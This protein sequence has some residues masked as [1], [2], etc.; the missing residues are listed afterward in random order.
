M[1]LQIK[2]SV[3]GDYLV[4]GSVPKYNSAV[5]IDSSLST[6]SQNAVQNKAVTAAINAKIATMASLEYVQSLY[7]IGTVYIGDTL[8][9]DFGTWE[10]IEGKFL[11]GCKSDFSDLGET[12]GSATVTLTQNNLPH[13]DATINAPYTVS[14]YTYSHNHTFK[15]NSRNDMVVSFSTEMLYIDLFLSIEQT[16]INNHVQSGLESISASGHNESANGTGAQGLS[17][18]TSATLTS[19]HWH[20]VSVNAYTSTHKHTANVNFTV[21]FGSGRPFSILPAYKAVTMWERTA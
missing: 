16:W 13:I 11:Y 18:V 21:S 4:A 14:S 15:L 6:I 9:F 10:T 19:D 3:N 17:T 1:S 2:D 20:N 12:G 5:A 7:P 8:P